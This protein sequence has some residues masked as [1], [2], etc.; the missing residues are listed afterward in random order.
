M[1]HP[2]LPDSAGDAVLIAGGARAILLQIAH[3]AIGRG[4]LEHSD[5]DDRP[6]D[7]LW[8]TLGYAYAVVFGTDAERAAAVRLVNRAHAPVRG[9]LDDGQRYTA[10]D[11][12]LQMWVAATLYDTAVTVH[13]ELFGPLDERTADAFYA[14]YS[15]LGTSL[16]VPAE[17]WP[18][19]RAAFREYWDAML[20]ALSADA[21]TRALSRRLMF[22]TSLP[23][24]LR[25]AMPLARLVT[26]GLLPPPVRELYGVR[27][28]PRAARR[29]SRIMR[30]AGAVWPLLPRG[31]RQWPK[32][33]ALR[34]ITLRA[35]Q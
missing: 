16:Q 13:A 27:W 12:A 31:I 2:D 18:A 6:L 11:P 22:A 28:T 26:A 7:R 9:A 35:R 10:Y 3:P 1:P 29:Y 34:T 21:S 20:P 33:Y 24:H 32:S 8:S 14:S 25:A 30:V 15:A 19:D 23:A 17:A 4:V 5:F